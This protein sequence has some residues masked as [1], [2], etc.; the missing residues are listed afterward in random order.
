MKSHIYDEDGLVVIELDGL[1]YVRYD[2]GA[3]QIVVR[4]D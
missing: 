4:E 3:H 2:A 1:F